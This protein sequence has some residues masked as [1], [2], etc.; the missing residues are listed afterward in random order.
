IDLVI[1]VDADDETVMRRCV[2]R[3]FDAETNSLYHL[4]FNPLPV[5]QQCLNERVVPL[6]GTSQI[7]YH[8][9]AYREEEKLMQEWFRP[10]GNLKIVKGT[11]DLA[12]V[13]KQLASSCSDILSFKKQ[14]FARLMV[15]EEQQRLQREAEEA[16]RREEERVREELRRFEE[17][18]LLE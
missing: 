4:E 1:R 6:D 16:V 3:R 12:Q 9:A 18:K 2:G 13:T 14:E 10:F 8:L 15:E 11:H 17:Q 5:D 7:R